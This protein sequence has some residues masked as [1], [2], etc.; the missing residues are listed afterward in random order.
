MR[1]RRSTTTIITTIKQEVAMRRFFI[2]ANSSRSLWLFI[3][4]SHQPPWIRTIP[5]Y[6][7]SYDEKLPNS[8]FGMFQFSPAMPLSSFPLPFPQQIFSEN[9]ETTK[10]FPEES[11]H[12]IHRSNPTSNSSSKRLDQKMNIFSSRM[13]TASNSWVVRPLPSSSSQ[14]ATAAREQQSYSPFWNSVSFG[15]RFAYMPIVI[16]SGRRRK[17]ENKEA[18]SFSTLVFDLSSICRV[19]RQSY[20][21]EMEN[22]RLQTKTDMMYITGRS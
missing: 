16:L 10:T 8:A 22:R 13:A 3:I 4:E 5:S 19:H 11:Y 1:R 18:F 9:N 14:P 6:T 15:S 7:P 20:R 2:T 12:P 17:C 21:R